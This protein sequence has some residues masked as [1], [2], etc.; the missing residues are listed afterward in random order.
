M[1]RAAPPGLCGGRVPAHPG[2]AHCLSSGACGDL[3]FLYFWALLE[4]F[5]FL[6]IDDCWVLKYQSFFFVLFLNKSLSNFHDRFV[7]G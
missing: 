4:V 2:F 1:T 3:C 6:V 7:C 5:N